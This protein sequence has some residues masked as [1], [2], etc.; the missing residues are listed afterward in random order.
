MDGQ[1]I[2]SL[3]AI[4]REGNANII[5]GSVPLT[6]AGRV[7]NSAVAIDRHGNV[8]TSYEKI[9]LFSLYGEGRFFAAGPMYTPLV[10]ANISE[11]IL[12]FTGKEFSS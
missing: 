5:A 1:L 6:I 7:Y 10:I 12:I 9:H 8:I 2:A 4:A 3:A 11:A